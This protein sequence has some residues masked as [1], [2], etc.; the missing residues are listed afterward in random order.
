LL[1]G[2]YR[3]V[4]MDLEKDPIRVVPPGES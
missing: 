2:L 4:V 3:V 1:H